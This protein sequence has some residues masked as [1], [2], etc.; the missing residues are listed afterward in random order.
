MQKTKRCRKKSKHTRIARKRKHAKKSRRRISRITRRNN[1]RGGGGFDNLEE[2]GE[3]ML[4]RKDRKAK[5]EMWNAQDPL[6][7]TATLRFLT[8]RYEIENIYLSDTL[9]EFREKIYNQLTT[10]GE[11]EYANGRRVKGDKIFKLAN[12]APLLN[13]QVKKEDGETVPL[14][15]G[16]DLLG[17]VL[18]ISDSVGDDLKIN[19]ALSNDPFIDSNDKI[20]NVKN[21]KELQKALSDDCYNVSGMLKIN[22]VPEAEEQ[23]YDLSERSWWN[24][25]GKMLYNRDPITCPPAPGFL[26]LDGNPRGVQG[27]EDKPVIQLG[28]GISRVGVGVQDGEESQKIPE[29]VDPSLFGIY[30]KLNLKC[31]RGIKFKSGPLMEKNYLRRNTPNTVS[32]GRRLWEGVNLDS[33]TYNKGIVQFRDPEVRVW[34][35]VF[36]EHAMV[37]LFPDGIRGSYDGYLKAMPWHGRPDDL[38]IG[39]FH[40]LYPFVPNGQGTYITDTARHWGGRRVRYI[41]NWKDGRPGRWGQEGTFGGGTIGEGGYGAP[42][43]KVRGVRW[44]TGME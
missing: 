2:V 5:I 39:N 19:A 18:N 34:D 7:V 43:G 25:W 27:E 41:G 12:M 31:A 1:Y 10:Q 30:D 22:L 36:A 13:L 9:N 3:D 33:E 24:T 21:T 4:R 38:T 35:P 20:I 32:T 42:W 16:I 6:P 23:V 44:G 26:V 11:T 14:Y 37:S 8:E 28:I 40:Q 17:E 29:D 15:R